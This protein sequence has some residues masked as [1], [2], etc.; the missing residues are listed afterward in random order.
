MELKLYG[1]GGQGVVTAAKLLAKAAVV[2]AGLYAQALPAYGHE[3]RGAP[4]YAY[5]RLAA[6]PIKEKCFVY[7]PDVVLV[8]APSVIDQGI[9]VL[10]GT[11]PDTIL[12]VNSRD[13]AAARLRTL[14]G[15]RPVYE[16]N[17]SAVAL[18]ETGRDIPNAAMLGAFAQ[19]ADIVS[20]DDVCAAI[21]ETFKG[22][23]GEI[24]ARAAERAYRETRRTN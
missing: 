19:V 1:L 14:A 3:R 16:V 5:L 7:R 9:A 18:A 10:E 12:V 23:A 15:N 4:V 17:A 6:A 20:L 2:H 13:E 21:A 24:N 22:K 8:F 11:G